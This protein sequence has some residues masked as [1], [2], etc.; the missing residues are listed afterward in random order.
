M[1]VVQYQS[2]ERP[3]VYTEIVPFQPKEGEVLLEIQNSALNHRDVFITKGLYPGLQTGVVLGS[4]GAGLWQGKPYLIN[5]NVDWGPNR[6]LPGENYSILGM[7]HHGTFSELIAIHPNRL[8]ELPEHLSLAEGSALPLAGLTAY[9]VLFTRCQLTPED[10]ICISGIGG[11]VALFVLQFA[12][13]TGAEVWVTSSSTKK[14]DRALE[15]GATGGI[16]YTSDSWYKTLKKQSG[17]FD[18]I[19]DS[20]GGEGFSNL[21]STANP[22]A[23]I[24]IY[25]GSKGAINKL[26]PQVIFWRHLNIFGS[27]MGS[28]QDFEAMVRFVSQHK[29]VPVVDSVYK[30]ADFQ[31]G[32][33]KMDR[34]DQFGKIVFD[35]KN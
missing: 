10:R 15:M 31:A 16:L 7:P 6:Q 26:S 11:G 23:R 5:P 13:A 25:G 34:G 8:A 20:A 12:L 9:R 28:D 24:G 17:G 21:I 4:D 29:I 27:T 33:D 35:N 3:A 30:L 18:V 22:G 19:I 1:R 32:F 2:A 14:I